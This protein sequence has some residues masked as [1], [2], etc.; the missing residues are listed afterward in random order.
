MNYLTLHQYYI[1]RCLQIAKNGLGTTQPNPMVG[2]LI[3][4]NNRIIGEGYTSPYGGP[5]AEVNAIAAVKNKHLLNKSTLYVT[6]EPCSH[7]GKTPPCSDLIIKYNIPKVVIGCKDDNPEVAGMGIAKLKASGC[8]VTVGVLENECKLHHRRFFTFYNKQRPYVIMK[9][10]E[11]ENGL[12]APQFKDQKR[13]VW[14]TN[15][16]SRQL[17]HKWRSEEQAILIGTSTVI[18]DNPSLTVRDWAGKNPTRVVLDRTLKL[19]NV[20]S[21]FKDD[22][23]D[24]IIVYGDAKR[25]LNFD[26]DQKDEILP[27]SKN[28]KHISIDWSQTKTIAHQICRLLQALNINSVIIEGG[29]KTL[30]TFIDEDLWDEARIFTGTSR[31]EKGITAPKIDGKLYSVTNIIDDKL[32]IYFNKAPGEIINHQNK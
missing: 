8:H 22:T 6:L 11:T 31:F 28:T 7:F 9:W 32:A 27:S 3:V 29:S 21:V 24:T 26:T 23:A 20:F 25:H 16:Y 10:A 17:V 13:P 14:I 4:Y 15:N 12:L 18:E 5:H 19:G 30:Q 2:A 1:K